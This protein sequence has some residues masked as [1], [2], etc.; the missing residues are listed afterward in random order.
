MYMNAT[1]IT[2]ALESSSGR[3]V[4]IHTFDGR[5]FNAKVTN[6]TPF[7]VN[8]VDNN[9]GVSVKMAKASISHVNA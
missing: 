8:F 3:F 5:K 9:T 7:Y 6:V 1:S 4:G 2:N